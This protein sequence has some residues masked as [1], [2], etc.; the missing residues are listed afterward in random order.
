VGLLMLMSGS[1]C[2]LRSDDLWKW[3]RFE[4]DERWRGGEGARAL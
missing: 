3:K 2:G 4:V 1:P